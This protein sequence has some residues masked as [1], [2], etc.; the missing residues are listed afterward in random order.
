MLLAIKSVTIGSEGFVF[1][2]NWVNLGKT[3]RIFHK[4][5]E[6]RCIFKKKTQVRD[7]GGVRASLSCE[8]IFL[9]I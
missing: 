4:K 1:K 7:K 6:V 8:V 3:Y 9:L 5:I 2:K